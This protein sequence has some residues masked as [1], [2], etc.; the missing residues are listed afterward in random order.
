[1]VPTVK[2]HAAGSVIAAQHRDSSS[3]KLLTDAAKSSRC[4]R[5][6]KRTS[7]ALAADDL[8]QLR[9]RQLRNEFFHGASLLQ[10]ILK[11][12]IRD[13]IRRLERQILIPSLAVINRANRYILIPDAKDRILQRIP[14]RQR[15]LRIR[16]LPSLRGKILRRGCGDIL[17]VR[18][19]DIRRNI[20]F[21]LRPAVHHH[22]SE[23]GDRRAG[24]LLLFDRPVSGDGKCAILRSDAD[25]VSDIFPDIQVIA[26]GLQYPAGRIPGSAGI[27]VGR[28]SSYRNVE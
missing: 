8:R 3:S 11:F 23:R 7:H 13:S 12:Q 18:S 17:R 20:R 24:F 5:R 27:I 22:S 25:S 15:C 16:H 21:I 10:Y 14:A 4:S 19:L 6:D 1:M 9:I 28:E 2:T 26:P